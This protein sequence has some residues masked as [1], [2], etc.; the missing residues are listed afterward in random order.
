[1]WHQTHSDMFSHSDRNWLVM[2]RWTDR[3][4]TMH[5]CCICPTRELEETTRESPYHVTEH[6]PARS[7]SLQPHT[8][9]SS[10][11]GLEP[12]SVETDVYVWRYALLV[13]HAR[14]EEEA[15]SSKKG[16]TW[17]RPACNERQCRVISGFPSIL[18]NITRYNTSQATVLSASTAQQYNCLP[19]AQIWI[20]LI[21]DFGIN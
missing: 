13:V 11:P 7:E 8:E 10:Q 1:M 5:I 21:K 20:L 12:L 4:T 2:Q 19:I 15:P 14:K 18:M 17:L 6:H 16:V 3:H 9:R